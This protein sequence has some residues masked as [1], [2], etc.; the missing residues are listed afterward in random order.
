MSVP[1]LLA[2]T[3]IFLAGASPLF[4]DTIVG[5]VVDHN[6]NGSVDYPHTDPINPGLCSG[7][8]T[9]RDETFDKW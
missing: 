2:R 5:R 8:F 6:G 7:P 3:L 9:P 4:A 1:L